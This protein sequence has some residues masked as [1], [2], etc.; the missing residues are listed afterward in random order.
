MIKHCAAKQITNRFSSKHSSS[1]FSPYYH[2]YYYYFRYETNRLKD[3]SKHTTCGYDQSTCISVNSWWANMNYYL[4]VLPFLGA[5][6]AGYMAYWKHHLVIRKPQQASALTKYYCTSVAEC[7][8]ITRDA[9][10]KWEK[11]FRYLKQISSFQNVLCTT[12]TEEVSDSKRNPVLD[13]I[14]KLMW[15][16]HVASIDSGLGYF[17]HLLPLMS[18]KESMFGVGWAAL[19]HFLGASRW[20]T[21]YNITLFFQVSLDYL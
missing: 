15:D 11:F 6:K 19:V 8:I 1:S 9:L 2:Y 3:F 14:L 21:N 10:K 7:N 4:S 13:E 17:Q 16:G 18:K 20:N 12:K 5:K